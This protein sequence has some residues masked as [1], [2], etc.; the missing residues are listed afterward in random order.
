[1]NNK[2]GQEEMVGFALI[3]I[4]VSVIILAFLGFFL[5]KSGSQSIQSYE[6]QSFIQSMLQTSTQCQDYYGYVSVQ[7][8][9]L[10]C[11]SDSQCTNSMDSC[12][13]LNSTL[14]GI[15]D[16]SWP[17]GQGTPIKGYNLNISASNGFSLNLNKGNV[18]LKSEGS[19]QDL[20]ESGVSIQVQ[21]IDYS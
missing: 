21:F 2:K 19:Y 12:N 10:M 13:V 20:S 1:M 14:S 16:Q 4:I 17:V 7:D 3:I 8:L 6:A 18:S 11:S 9:I 5:S 15:L